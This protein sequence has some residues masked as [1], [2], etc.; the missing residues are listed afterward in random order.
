MDN[1]Q[2]VDLALAMYSN[3]PCR[4]CGRILTIEDIRAGAVWAGY[5]KESSSRVAHKACWDN[6]M[7]IVREM[8][9]GALDDK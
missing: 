6:A 1:T 5:D 8:Y 9:P 2:F 3:E 7:E 4:I